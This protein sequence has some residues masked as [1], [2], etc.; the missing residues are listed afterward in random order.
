M[1]LSQSPK[2]SWAYTVLEVLLAFIFILALLDAFKFSHIDV[3]MSL[4]FFLIAV[5]SFI[6][7]IL[8]PYAIEPEP[9]TPWIC[10][11]P[12]I[13]KEYKTNERI[14]PIDSISDKPKPRR[15]KKSK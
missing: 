8:M 10:G 3:Q 13:E 9:R 15:K 2:Y 1:M 6:I 14:V 5:I 7:Y 11:T 12:F 4:V